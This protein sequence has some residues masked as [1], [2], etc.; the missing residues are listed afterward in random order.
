A[1]KDGD[2][3]TP[4]TLPGDTPIR[5]GRNHVAD[6]LFSPGGNPFDLLDFIEGTLPQGAPFKGRFHGDKPL[7]RGPEDDRIMTAPAVR[8]RMFDLFRT[9]K[10]ISTLEQLHDRRIRFKDALAVILSKA[11]AEPSGFVY[12]AGLVE[13]VL[14][15]CVEIIC[16]M[17]GSRMD[18]AG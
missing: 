6:A 3:Y 5:T 4:N 12:V 7:L 16:T 18:C 14:R 17:R 1:K 8:I 15:S 13:V 11:V 10:N 2:R 9:Q